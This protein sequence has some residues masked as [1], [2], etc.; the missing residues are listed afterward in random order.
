VGRDNIFLI[1]IFVLWR[2][3]GN[4]GKFLLWRVSFIGSSIIENSVRYRE[5]GSGLSEY[6]VKLNGLSK[7]N[8]NIVR[9][10]EKYGTVFIH[11]KGQKLS[12]I[13]MGNA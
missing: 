6:I 11:F 1:G 7:N 5:K 8:L 4:C 10:I 3:W 2:K 12:N 9:N 13:K